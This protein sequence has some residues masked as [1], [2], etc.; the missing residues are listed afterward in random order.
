MYIWKTLGSF[1]IILLMMPL[2]HAAMILMEHHLD[3]TPLHYCGF[4]MGAVGLMIVIAGVF[5][6]RDTPATICGLAG[7][8]LFWTGW[9]EFLFSYYA[10]RYGV[11]C[12]LLGS[13]VIQTTTQY[14]DGIGVSH[15]FLLNGAPLDTYDRPTLKLI[16]GSRPEYL[17]M[18]ATFGMWMMIAMLYLFCTRTGCRFFSWWQRVLHLPDH[19]HIRPL[20]HLPAMVTFLELNVMMWTMY[21]VLMFCYDP[22]FLGSHHLITYIVAFGCLIGSFF[23]LRKQLRIKQWGANIRMGIATVLVFWS[24]VEVAARNGHF[25]E[26]WIDPLNHIPEMTAILICFLILLAALILGKKTART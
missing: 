24:F 18:P 15:E 13:G 3:P 14:V 6:K 22:V 23:M 16:R 26:I 25:Q 21:L 9:V 12:D 1:L 17:I 19:V 7:G 10:W 11:H 5:V 2:G 8:L 20:T 4:A